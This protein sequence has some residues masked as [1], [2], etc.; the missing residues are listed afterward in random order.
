MARE[1]FDGLPLNQMPAGWTPRYNVDGILWEVRDANETADPASATDNVL[2]SEIVDGGGR[3]HKLTWDEHDGKTYVELY[4][5]GMNNVGTFW[6]WQNTLVI[7]GD[8]DGTTEFGYYLEMERDGTTSYIRLW[9]SGSPIVRFQFVWSSNTWYHIKLRH[10]TDDV[11]RA[12]IWEDGDVEPGW[13]IQFADDNPVTGGWHGVGGWSLGVKH[14]DF[15]E[16]TATDP[17]V[18]VVSEF[19]ALINGG[20]QRT[21]NF[22]ALLQGGTTRAEQFQFDIDIGVARQE[23]FQALITAGILNVKT[24][25]PL[26]L[27]AGIIRRTTAQTLL[28]VG[29][30]EESNTFHMNLD[31]GAVR[32]I[33]NPMLLDIG[34]HRQLAHNAVVSATLLNV[35]NIFAMNLNVG[36]SRL[37]QHNTIIQVGITAQNRF[38]ALLDIGSL[39]SR[40]F[41]MDLDIA[42]QRKTEH[43]LLLEIGS[44][45]QREYPANFD[46]GVFRQVAFPFQLTVDVMNRKLEFP[47]DIQVVLD[48]DYPMEL[49]VGVQRQILFPA[50]FDVNVVRSLQFPMDININVHR[51]LQF[52][53]LADVG[54]SRTNTHPFDLVTGI[55]R[56]QAFNHMLQVGVM[57]QLA[58]QM[59]LIFGIHQQLP[60]AMEVNGGLKQINLSPLFMEISLI[61]RLLHQMRIETGIIV[62]SQFPQTFNAGIIRQ[63]V[64]P[65]EYIV[66]LLARLQFELLVKGGIVRVGEFPINVMSGVNR[67]LDFPLHLTADSLGRQLIFPMDFIVADLVTPSMLEGMLTAFWNM[68]T[69]DAELQ[70]LLD[71]KIKVFPS[72]AERDAQFPYIIHR[73]E[74]NP[75]IPMALREASYFVHIWDYKDRADRLLQIRDHIIR[76]IDDKHFDVN[77]NG[78]AIAPGTGRPGTLLAESVRTFSDTEQFVQKEDQN[79]WQYV[80]VFHVRFGRT[81]DLFRLGL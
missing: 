53:L 71:R 4:T 7:N 67:Q 70:E 44:T 40:I 61:R 68:I 51:T 6:T 76:I 52:P 26:L 37:I 66:G 80:I 62:R 1:N 8:F 32:Q 2:R 12:K 47:M 29:L 75:L 21:E 23:E 19:P 20:I 41:P 16:I 78:Q 30:L 24:I 64:A 46:I 34:V 63:I 14:F 73:F 59:N 49:D 31:I 36:V 5:K 10:D 25:N 43:E 81:W 69:T 3:T 74:L 22:N 42:V 54:I 18:T 50:N 55:T 11:I 17:P 56:T 33:V 57:R 13:Q 27:E 38:N 9:R 60:F 35:S 15:V 65:A 72:W 77:T 28:N 39:Q 58:H 45:Q 48:I 79:I